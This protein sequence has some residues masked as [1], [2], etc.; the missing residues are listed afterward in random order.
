VRASCGE[1]LAMVAAASGGWRVRIW[2]W[3][4]FGGVSLV[5]GLG[6]VRPAGAATVSGLQGCRDQGETMDAH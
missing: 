1:I 4:R 6:N 3:R 5:L 2:I